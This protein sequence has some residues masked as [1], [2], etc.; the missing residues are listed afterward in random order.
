[1]ARIRSV[2]P[3]ICASEVMA[4]LS[5]DLERTFV[6][7]WTHCDDEGRCLDNPKLI[8]AA[9]YPLHDGMTAA[10]VEKELAQLEAVGLILRYSANGTRV[11]A[12]R[13]WNEYQHP[14]RPSAS[15]L[16]AYDPSV[17]LADVSST[18]IEPSASVPRVFHAGVGVGE[19]EGE[20]VI[21]PIASSRNVPD[22][23]R[24][25]V[26]DALLEACGIA[27]QV[28]ASARGAYGKAVKDLRE[29][30][31]SPVAISA[32]AQVFRRRWPEASLTPTALAR[33]WAECEPGRNLATASADPALDVVARSRQLR[34]EG[35]IS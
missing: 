27:G 4:D 15:K 25:L 6:R 18:P 30:G 7:L 20:G 13:S 28:P 23:P 21:A 14:Q 19:G 34:A 29:V 8:K 12:V 10:R 35:L 11:L 9:I 5:G 1:M 16:P 17:A 32:R 3:D 31:A 22:R 24:D 26:W 33:R 2:H